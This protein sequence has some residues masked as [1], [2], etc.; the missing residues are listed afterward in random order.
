MRDGRQTNS[1]KKLYGLAVENIRPRSFSFR[2]SITL[3]FLSPKIICFHI[4]PIQASCFPISNYHSHEKSWWHWHPNFHYVPS[5]GLVCS[6]LNT[7]QL[8][9]TIYKPVANVIE[10]KIETLIPIRSSNYVIEKKLVVYMIE[11]VCTVRNR[12]TLGLRGP[13]PPPWKKTL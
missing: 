3:F 9:T 4:T 1:G 2:T 10:K 6:T 11:M 12:P 7:N 5:F 8:S 13:W